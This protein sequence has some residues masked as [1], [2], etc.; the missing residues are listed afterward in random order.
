MF[1]Q[2]TDSMSS[3]EQANFRHLVLDIAWAG[4][5][6]AATSRFLS[7]FA[8]RLGA[9]A[10]DLS[11]LTSLPALILLF[12]AS[13]SGWWMRR[14]KN[15]TRALFF[16]GFFWRFVFLLP[17]FAPWVPEKWQPLYLILSASLPAVV[18]GAAATAFVVL[19][20]SSVQ[21]RVMPSLLSRRSMALNV[22]VGVGALAFGLW[23]E[24]SAFPQNY[25]LMY[26]LA[27]VMA[28]ISFH[29]CM[30]L[31]SSP[32]ECPLVPPERTDVPD[33][34]AKP[35]KSPKF[36]NVALVTMTAYIAYFSVASLIPLHL[37]NS[38]GASEGFIALYG[39]I[40]LAGGAMASMFT[41]QIS[42]RIGTRPMIAFAMVG[43]GASVLIVALSP[44]LP[45]TLIGAAVSGASWTTAATVGLFAYFNE[46]A[47]TDH[48]PDYSAA[49]HQVVGLA[50]FIGP[51]IGSFLARGNADLMTVLIIGAAIRIAAA[52][53][54]D[55]SLMGTIK[56]A[57]PAV[58]RFR[59]AD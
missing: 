38:L 2:R 54:I 58:L 26:G 18:Q 53:L 31:D 46:N 33:T 52:P 24:H 27:F 7:V 39:I 25:Q 43:T 35:W 10:T 30:S 20:R 41:P 42:R 8:I 51:M 36:R 17:A 11:W 3:I 19:M 50:T 37:V 21:D 44:S 13:V 45:F 1:F 5:A 22:T 57:V 4:I 40:E 16:P 6:I 9:T 15:A 56:A 49:Y 23:L 48:M 29:H 14:F 32:N 12:S 55:R 47:P 28:M 34:I 59:H